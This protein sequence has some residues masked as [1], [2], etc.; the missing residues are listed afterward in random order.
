MTAPITAMMIGEQAA[1][2]KLAPF[3]SASVERVRIE[4]VRTRITRFNRGE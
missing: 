1:H 4:P 2:K 3:G